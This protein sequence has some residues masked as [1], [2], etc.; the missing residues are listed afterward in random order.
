QIEQHGKHVELKQAESLAATDK[1]PK[2]M[3]DEAATWAAQPHMT[4]WLRL[5]P[6]LADVDLSPYFYFSRDRLSPA[7]PAARL[8]AA[9]QELLGRLEHP[10][11]ATRRTAIDEGG[12]LEAGEVV[13]IFDVLLER[14]SRDPRGHALDSAL[15]LAALK[16]ELVGRLAEALDALPAGS[17]PVQLP[18]KLVAAIDPR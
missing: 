8:P 14:G 16:P 15:E 12:S 18:A 3:S 1:K 6:P 13:Q 7:A 11:G 4:P 10:V 9:L 17:V 2:G 5:E